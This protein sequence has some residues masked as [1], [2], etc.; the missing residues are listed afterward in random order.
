[1]VIF[2]ITLSISLSISFFC[3]LMEACLLSLSNSNIAEI[4][5]KSPKAANIWRRF[6]SNIQK[7]IAVILIVNTLAHT[8]G[9]TVS[10]AKFDDLFGQKWLWIFSLVYSLIMIQYTEILPKTLGVRF[11]IILAKVSA[12]PLFVLVR[13]FRPFTTLIEIL[14]SPFER[15]KQKS[16]NT[17]ADEI[18]LL[19][20]SADLDNS[21]SHEQATVIAKAIQLAGKKVSDIMIEK[22]DVIALMHDMTLTDAFLVAH[23]H[24][25]T[26]YPI[27]NSKK[28]DKV[29]GYVNF[30]D[31]VTAL[32]INPSDPSLKGICRPMISLSMTMP[33]N[34]ALNKMMRE[35]SH[36]AVVTDIRN[37]PIGMIALENIIE[38]LVG[39]IEDEFDRPPEMV[40]TLGEKRWRVGGGTTVAKLR[41]TILNSVPETEGTIDDLV[42]LNIPEDQ[43]KENAHFLFYDFRIR[44]RRIARDFV[45]DVIIEKID[46]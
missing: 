35:Y 3:S 42:K 7:P 26:R 37:R 46:H 11:N 10:G 14:N 1:M 16:P 4:S 33:L 12:L 23:V 32:H 20:G 17:I 15:K 28:W 6:K 41:E 18:M 13:V 43:L 9:A 38:S 29:I 5:Q 27:V 34:I 44:V 45:Y 39:E 2:L 24:K 30:K 25:H 31:I 22:E 40:V 8:I 19:S 21:I 36:I